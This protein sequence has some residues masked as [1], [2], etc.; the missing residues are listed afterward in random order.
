MTKIDRLSIQGNTEG[1]DEKKISHRRKTPQDGAGKEVDHGDPAEHMSCD[2][3]PSLLIDFDA[4]DYGT[5]GRQHTRNYAPFALPV[6]AKLK[7]PVAF[8]V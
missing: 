5:W 2:A 1:G 8:T 4:M 3:Y 7:R 6:F